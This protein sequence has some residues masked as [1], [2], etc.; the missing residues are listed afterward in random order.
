MHSVDRIIESFTPS[1]INNFIE[2]YIVSL[3][4][5]MDKLY[6]CGSEFIF[7]KI[8]WVNIYIIKSI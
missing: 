2:K 4:K 8:Q 1:Y 5:H 3:A 7:N 6:L